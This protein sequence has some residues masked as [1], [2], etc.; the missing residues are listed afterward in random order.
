MGFYFVIKLM[1][2]DII[3]DV[4]I[5]FYNYSMYSNVFYFIKCSIGV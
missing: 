1:F 4:L 2:D 5:F 3:R